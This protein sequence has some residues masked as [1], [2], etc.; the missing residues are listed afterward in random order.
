MRSLPFDEPLG[1]G[2]PRLKLFAKVR[3]II[4]HQ[5][6]P[7]FT[8]SLTMFDDIFQGLVIHVVLCPMLV[9]T[10]AN[11]DEPGEPLDFTPQHLERIDG[12]A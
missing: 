7:D 11:F 4:F 2:L 9:T 8:P 6:G 3:L 10:F 5:E 1:R 12:I